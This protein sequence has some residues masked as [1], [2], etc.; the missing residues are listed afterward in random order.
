MKLSRALKL[1]E[2]L[3]KSFVHH[4]QDTIDLHFYHQ[5]LLS[6]FTEVD[7]I[8][9][10][11]WFCQSIYSKYACKMG[12]TGMYSPSFYLPINST[13]ETSLTCQSEL[14]KN[15]S[16]N[17]PAEFRVSFNKGVWLNSKSIFHD[18]GWCLYF[19]LSACPSTLTYSL[20]W[21]TGHGGPS[22]PASILFNCSE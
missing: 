15:A 8:P 1:S 5:H 13:C 6:P 10:V 20:H 4:I 22:G 7:A 19:W 16:K 3:I 14:A 21:T 18:K 9:F 12:C 11:K 17:N 2:G